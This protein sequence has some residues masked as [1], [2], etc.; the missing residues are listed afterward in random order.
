MLKPKEI[1]LEIKLFLRNPNGNNEENLEKI[2]DLVI[3]DNN[4]EFN[5]MKIGMLNEKGVGNLIN[6]FWNFIKMKENN[7]EISYLPQL[8]NE[9]FVVKDNDE[10]EN[11]KISSKFACT[12]LNY[13]NQKFENVIDNEKKISHFDICNDI[14]KISEGQ[15]FQK[16]FMERIKNQKINFNFLDINNLVI[17]SGGNYDLSNS[18]ETDKNYLT[19]DVIICKASTKY[20]DYN[21]NLIRTYMIDADKEQQKNYKIL[22]E[23]FNKL[24]KN[25]KEGETI[26][27]VY[28]NVL[29]EIISRD[30]NLV[31]NLCSNFG[32]GIGLEFNNEKLTI[33]NENKEIIKKGMVFN[34]RM[35]FE[36]L[37]KNDFKYSLQIADTIVVKGNEIE[38][39]T[40]NISK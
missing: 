13:L 19:S 15:N 35:S 4:N 33:N 38:N 26:S 23:A 37:K 22:L 31:E 30:S 1:S 27:K 7:F 14:K 28:E 21:S 39:F 10:L 29:N 25:L 20:H 12:L 32:N 11:I 40:A 5:K 24:E 2:F 18:C 9:F 17:Q 6:E 16:K 34:I 8:T 3:K 36:N